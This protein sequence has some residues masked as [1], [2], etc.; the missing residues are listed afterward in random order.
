MESKLAGVPLLVYANKQDL[1]N[2]AP[3][4]EISTGL[5]LLSIRDREWQI[6]P[7]SAHTGEGVQVDFS[8][9]FISISLILNHLQQGL[10]WAL[11]SVEA[12]KGKSK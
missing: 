5:N 9:I 11:S 10:E 6:Q 1:M 4:S 12:R 2:A 3:A 7:C 8:M